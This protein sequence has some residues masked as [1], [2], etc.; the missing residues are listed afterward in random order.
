MT[1]DLDANGILTVSAKVG[2][3]AGKSLTIK[4]DKGRLSEADIERMCAEADKYKEE[5]TKRRERIDAKNQ[6]E[7]TLYGAKNNMDNIPEHAKADVKTFLDEEFAWLDKQN[8]DTSAETFNKRM[9]EFSGKMSELSTPKHTMNP[10]IAEV[11]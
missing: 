11:D 7:N 5:D 6:Y 4:N 10:D 8:I 3:G 9:G 2:E 1:Y